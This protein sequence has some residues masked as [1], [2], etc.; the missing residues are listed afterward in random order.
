MKRFN[1]QHT[2]PIIGGEE[3]EKTMNKAIWFSRHAL[4]EE[5]AEEIA[6]AGYEVISDAKVS[7][8]AKQNITS[9]EEVMNIVD[10]FM[11][12]RNHG[13]NRIY[14]VFPPALRSALL[15]WTGM[16][17]GNTV[18]LWEAWNITR[19]PDG[20]KPTFE[21]KKFVLTFRG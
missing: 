3:R 16:F 1:S 21:H 7:E 19:S 15:A 2:P 6:A 18:E 12:L 5:Q 13:V 8:M 4:T 10:S 9:E 20:G 17:G 14:G 11:E